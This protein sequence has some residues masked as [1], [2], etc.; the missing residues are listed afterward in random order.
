MKCIYLNIHKVV[1]QKRVK[2]PNH[3]K[4]T[5]TDRKEYYEEYQGGFIIW[6]RSVVTA[7]L[8]ALKP[9]GSTPATTNLY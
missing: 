8:V 7:V 6:R 1:R 9:R 3:L 4:I 2:I 5:K